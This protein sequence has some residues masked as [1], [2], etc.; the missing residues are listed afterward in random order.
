MED[1]S[2]DT[3]ETAAVKLATRLKQSRE[4][5]AFGMS[6]VT[7]W[8]NSGPGGAPDPVHWGLAGAGVGGLAGLA[9]SF[10]QNKDERRPFSSALTGAIAG[11]AAAGGGALAAPA[12]SRMFSGLQGSGGGSS[13]SA[14]EAAKKYLQDQGKT[15]EQ[16]HDIYAGPSLVD[17]Y[18]P[19]GERFIGGYGA[20]VAGQSA[21]RTLVNPLGR[22][23]AAV[24]EKALPTGAGPIFQNEISHMDQLKALWSAMRGRGIDPN[25]LT[26][27]PTRDW[28]GPL[29]QAESAAEASE[30]ALAGRMRGLTNTSVKNLSSAGGRSLTKTLFNLPAVATGVL[31]AGAPWLMSKVHPMTPE[32]LTR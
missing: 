14:T 5:R 28:Q 3:P 16:L 18:T 32:Q 25:V 6:D 4:K 12:L 19:A 31:A 9:S 21:Y 17:Q 13:P 26:Q 8:L 27:P 11:G 20:G 15:P 24:G 22:G 1:Y 30:A 29:S 7:G 2:Q 23:A 10:G